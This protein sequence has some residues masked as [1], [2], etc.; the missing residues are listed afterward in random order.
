MRASGGDVTSVSSGVVRS[1]RGIGRFVH[2]TVSR[3]RGCSRA[4]ARAPPSHKRGSAW[5]LAQYLHVVREA[6]AAAPRFG[7]AHTARAVVR[8]VLVRADAAPPDAHA[9]ADRRAGLARATA[10]HGVRRLVGRERGEV[11]RRDDAVRVK[12]AQQRGRRRLGDARRRGA[13]R[14]ARRAEAPLAL[15]IRN[16]FHLTVAST[17]IA[18][19]HSDRTTEPTAG[20]QPRRIIR[21]HPEES[22]DRAV[23]RVVALLFVLK[24]ALAVLFA[25]CDEGRRLPLCT[26]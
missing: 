1:R 5:H 9:A 11:R 2:N 13:R 8:R 7:A 17:T 12:C 14:S 4:I 15:H 22:D 19:V 3:R 6:A 20:R 10:P 26:A 21:A 23:S 24:R 16:A 18:R 25:C